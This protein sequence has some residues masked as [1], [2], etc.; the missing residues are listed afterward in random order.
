MTPYHADPNNYGAEHNFRFGATGS[1]VN[2]SV[3]GS[4]SLLYSITS[5]GWYTFEMTY[6]KG[7]S[8]TDPVI[9]DMNIL[10]TAGNILATQQVSATSPGGPFESQDLAGSGYAWFPVWQNGFAG[11]TLDVANM[12]TGLL[13]AAVPEPGI[14]SALAG[15]CGMG[16]V[17]LVWRRRK[18]TA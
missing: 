3:D 2:V 13:P 4:N 5:T 15:L 9:T 11:D 1:E 8:P 6:S 12:D 18:Q 14:F 17:G 7:A 10:D 16:V